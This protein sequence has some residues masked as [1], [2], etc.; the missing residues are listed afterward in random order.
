MTFKNTKSKSITTK[1]KHKERKPTLADYPIE[2]RGLPNNR[3]GG[4]QSLSL[5]PFKGSTFGAAGPV[6]QYTADEIRQFE[7][8]M[9]KSGQL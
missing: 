8:Q 1:Q 2:L 3:W 6:K 9:R 5:K 7:L 4:H